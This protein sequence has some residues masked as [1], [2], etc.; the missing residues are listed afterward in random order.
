MSSGE[1]GKDVSQKICRSDDEVAMWVMTEVR[2]LRQEYNV[3]S[4][5]QQNISAQFG[6]AEENEASSIQVEF[7]SSK[8]RVP[9]S[10]FKAINIALLAE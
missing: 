3:Y 8:L 2:S 9:L 6:G 7:R 4:P 1:E 10:G 5:R